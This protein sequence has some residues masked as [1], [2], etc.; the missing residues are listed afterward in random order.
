MSRYADDHYSRD[1]RSSYSHSHSRD[2]DHDWDYAP[3]TDDRQSYERGS[4]DDDNTRQLTIASPGYTT[5][6]GVPPPSQTPRLTYEPHH[7]PTSLQIPTKDDDGSHSRPRSLPP[8][9][10]YHHHTQHQHYQPQPRRSPRRSSGSSARD[11]EHTPVGRTR[12]FVDS[13]FTDSRAGIGVGVLGA[14]VG[15]LAAREATSKLGSNESG[16]GKG[17]RRHHSDADRRNH[18][19]LGAV[20]GAA[21]GALGANAVEKRIERERE[22]ERGREQ[23]D[24]ERKW[25]RGKGRREGSRGVG[26]VIER[27]E[28]VKSVSR[29]RDRDREREREGSSGGSGGERRM[30]KMRG[31]GGGG[32]GVGSGRG[33]EREVDPGARSW[34]NVE[35]WLEDE[36]YCGGIADR[37][38]E[39]G[40]M[41][42]RGGGSG[43]GSG[44]GHWS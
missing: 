22:R 8:L 10:D 39:E 13:T 31:G 37:D 40:M 28:L 4:D 29:S 23:A 9:I 38:A 18:Q 19:I 21:V 41:V 42:R 43:G 26:E 6:N 15:G 30:M 1:R 33:I 32:G 7:H 5:Y 27:R 16:K 3:Y 14:L 2:R 25:G 12:H 44:S 11:R 34:K 36:E 17:R 24:W 35:D 20:V